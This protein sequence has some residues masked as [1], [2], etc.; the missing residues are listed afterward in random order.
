MYR[1]LLFITLL[2][3]FHSEAIDYVLTEDSLQIF[4]ENPQSAIVS[5]SLKDD[6]IVAHQ[7]SQKIK[8][9]LGAYKLGAVKYSTSTSECKID[10]IT[11]QG[12]ALICNGT[13]SSKKLESLFTLVFTQN[14]DKID[15]KIS[16]ENQAINF[17]E[18]IFSST[19]ETQYF[20]GG[21]QFSF[22]NLKG[23]EIPMLVEEN[24]IGRGDDKVTGLAKIFGVQGSEYTTYAPIPFF[25]G[26]DQIA[27]SIANTTF[28]NVDFRVEDEVKIN[29]WDNTLSGSFWQ[30]NSPKELLTKYTKETGRMQPLPSF[31][32]G[33][34][35]GLQGG[36]AKVDSILKQTMEFNNPITA[37]WIQD[38]V[39]KRETSIGR[40]L[41]WD[42]T[43]NEEVYPDFE[44]WVD[45]LNQIGIKVLGYINPY[46]VKD[47]EHCNY[48]LAHDYVVKDH[49]GKHY[50][51][52]AGGFDAYMIDFTNPAANEWYQ[53]IIIE[54]MLQKGLS[55][56]MADFGEWLPMDAQL[57]NGVDAESYHNQYPVDWIKLNHEAIEKSGFKDI[58]I[59][60]RSGF[61]ESAKY[62]T[63]FWVGDQ[64][65]NYGVNDGML[66]AIC[67][68]N[69]SGMSGIG[70]NHTDI[71]GYTAIKFGPFKHLRDRDIL[72]RWMEMAAFT[73]IFRTHEGL[74]PDDMSQFY[75]DDSSQA[76]FAKMAQ[77]HASLQPL[78]EELTLEANTTGIPIIRHPYLEFPEDKNTYHLRHQFMLGDSLMVIPTTES[79]SETNSGYLPQGKW[80]HFFT[81]KIVEGGR[82]VKVKS[83]YGTP[84]VFKRLKEG[85]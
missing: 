38:W 85:E 77:V 28:S 74:R 26:T 27:F 35:L 9:K 24:G 73:P 30:A 6:F 1:F 75:S 54:N 72:Y 36:K 53:S 60:N 58:L 23:H 20:G 44:N 40:R 34:I 62:S 31:A 3:P 70:I 19:P 47:G 39:G 4:H 45:S 10:K 12:D 61:N 76:F 81:N 82:F 59:F 55:G 8:E 57:Y 14:D 15:Y 65:A 22:C 71:G 46:L 33:T 51:F 11:K 64:M 48:A 67:A 63:S 84:T 43:A 7:A 17:I 21:E 69:S 83:P 32:Y 13:V 56:W 66:S 18:F 79:N 80:Q 41:Q 37:I 78:F 52:K 16:F 5:F 25:M 68:L 50:V 29:I 49:K 2:F 42:W